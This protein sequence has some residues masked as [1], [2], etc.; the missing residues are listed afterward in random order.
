MLVGLMFSDLEKRILPDELTKGGIVVG[1][2]FSVFVPV[3]DVM[4][5]TAY[6]LLTHGE[7]PAWL[8]GWNV[9]FCYGAALA[10]VANGWSGYFDNALEALGFPLPPALVK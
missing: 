8:A 9:L 7:L 2:I 3:P 5:K 4:A 6:W 10:A 1:L